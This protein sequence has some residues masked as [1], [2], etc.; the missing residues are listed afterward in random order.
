MININKDAINKLENEI[1]FSTK[2]KI[3]IVEG[4]NDSK[5]LKPFFKENVL[6]LNPNMV[7]NN[8]GVVI[9]VIE[10]LSKKK[11]ENSFGGKKVIGIIDADFNRING[12]LRNDIQNL[13]YTDTHD[14]DSMIFSTNALEKIIRLLYYKPENVNIENLRKKCFEIASEFGIYLLSFYD[15]NIH[16][17]K[18]KFKPIEQFFD[19]DLMFFHKKVI[20]L[21]DELMGKSKSDLTRIKLSLMQRKNLNLDHYQMANGHDLVRVFIMLTLW[22]SMNLTKKGMIDNYTDDLIDSFVKREKL[23]KEFENILRISYEFDFFRNSNLYKQIITYE[24]TI[25]I[26]FLK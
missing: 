24:Q 3:L 26:N 9:E 4:G 25:G 21:L 6:I 20:K 1:W 22:R 17:L 16:N 7:S 12:K 5:V 10:L 18:E 13:F 2:K 15:N 11:E 14:I 23:I 8:K 19:K